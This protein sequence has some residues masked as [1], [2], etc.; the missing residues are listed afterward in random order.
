MKGSRMIKTHFAIGAVTL[1]VGMMLAAVL[2]V[3]A[4]GKTWAQMAAA[5]SA[6]L[7]LL[8]ATV[9]GV[10]I[11]STVAGKGLLILAAFL[12]VA[13]VI[14][15]V[16]LTGAR[17]KDDLE[18]DQASDGGQGAVKVDRDRGPAAS[19]SASVSEQ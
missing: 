15:A 9:S 12:A 16:A 1:F 8:V 18:P 2:L 6:V 10:K 5:G 17:G 7:A 19:E 13:L 11:R 3:S 14:F 4:D